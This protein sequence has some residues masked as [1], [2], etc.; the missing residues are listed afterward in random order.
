MAQARTRAQRS[1]ALVASALAH[2]ALLAAA[3]IVLP[4]AAKEL[5]L[6]KSV[7][8]TIVTS[9]PPAEMAP[10][11]QAPEPAPAATPEPVESAPAE[12]APVT[13]APPAPPV[14]AAP[15][16]PAQAKAAPPKPGPAAKPAAAAA[17]S[18][19]PDKSDLDLEALMASIRATVKPSAKAVSGVRGP[20]RPRADV[21][22]QQ[23]H[24]ADTSMSASETAGLVSK[25][26]KLWNPNCQ[27]EGAASVKVKVHMRLTRSGNLIGAPDLPDLGD[28][29]DRSDVVAAAARRAVSAVNRGQPYTELNPDHYD[30]WKDLNVNFDGASACAAR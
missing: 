27:V 9:G 6:G 25:L 26:M 28:V 1:P 7:P 12:P 21:Q 5:P 19:K 2:A 22:V 14:Q 20:T 15:S 17:P 13:P 10:A 8:V 29:S 16:K 4:H 24:G 18:A 30:G 3:L 11:V 23:G